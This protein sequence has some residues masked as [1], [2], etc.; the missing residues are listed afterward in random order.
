MVHLQ[1]QRHMVAVV[2]ALLLL[3]AMALTPTLPRPNKAMVLLPAMVHISLHSPA[4]GK[5]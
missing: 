2:M 5:S 1:H 4:H 3:V